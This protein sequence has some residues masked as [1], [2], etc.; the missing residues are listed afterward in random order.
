MMAWKLGPALACGKSSVSPCHLTYHPSI[1]QQAMSSFSNQ[2]NKHHS[3]HSI[4]LLLSKKYVVHDHVPQS[5]HSLLSSSSSSSRLAFRQVLS[6]SYQVTQHISLSLSCTLLITISFSK[7][8]GPECG[9]A[10]AVHE[11]IDKVAFTGSVEVRTVE[12]NDNIDL[13]F[14]YR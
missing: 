14:A 2:R 10:I 6:T 13:M 8:D 12:W 3:L 11:H 1:I 5:V 9:Y 4:V 7:G